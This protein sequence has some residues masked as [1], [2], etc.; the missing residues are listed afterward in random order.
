MGWPGASMDKL[1]CIR[2]FVAVVQ[3]G[4]FAAAARRLGR[5][6][7][8]VTK[9]VQSLERQM[10]TRLLNRTT[11]QVSLT[12]AGE[13][14][15][16]HCLQVLDNID[17]AEAEVGAIN[18]MPRGRLKVTASYD[19]GINELEPLVLDFLARYPEI[20]VDLVLVDHFV[21]LIKEGF[22][23][24]VESRGNYPIQP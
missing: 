11:R 21:D 2:S 19:F 6:P 14:F 13:I 17:R 22:D 7:A 24:A 3:A 12:E 4:S 15:W 1:V 10:R 5:A 16:R 20:T 23:V 18:D 9:H 8:V